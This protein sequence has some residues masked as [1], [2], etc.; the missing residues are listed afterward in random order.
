MDPH[1]LLTSPHI[2]SY[3]VTVPTTTI[4]ST[5]ITMHKEEQVTSVII[6]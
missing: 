5:R 3:N 6:L 2:I 4:N 1:H